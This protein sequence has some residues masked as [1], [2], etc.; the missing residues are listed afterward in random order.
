[1]TAIIGLAI[2]AYTLYMT[3]VTLG[4]VGDTNKLPSAKDFLLLFLSLTGVV[5]GYYFGRI[6]ADA[7][8]AQTQQQVM[9]T[10]AQN[11][12]VGAKA[13]QLAQQIGTIME[14]IRGTQG[15]SMDEATAAELEQMRQQLRG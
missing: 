10:T 15:S 12:Q 8:S 2:I 14:K 6:P 9:N 11:A 4:M 13:E 5:L 7:R 3:T 1:V